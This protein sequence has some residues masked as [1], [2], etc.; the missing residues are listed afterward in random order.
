MLALLAAT[1]PA[2]GGADGPAATARRADG[3][4]SVLPGSHFELDVS[5]LPVHPNSA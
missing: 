2:E 4:C 1:R 3:T 5:K